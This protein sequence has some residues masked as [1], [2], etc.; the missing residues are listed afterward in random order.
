MTFKLFCC[1]L[2]CKIL[3]DFLRK[4]FIQGKYVSLVKVI[5][6]NVAILQLQKTIFVVYFSQRLGA[7]HSKHWWSKYTT[8]ICMDPK[9]T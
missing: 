7:A 1:F 5:C 9:Q 6:K 4:Y 2:D 8:N 3:F